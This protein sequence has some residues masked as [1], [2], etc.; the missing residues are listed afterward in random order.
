MATASYRE[1]TGRGADNYQRDF[2]P[3]IAT[4]VSEEL[5]RAA[6]LRPGERVLDVACGTGLIAR[7]AAEQVGPTGSVVGV[8]VAPD[9]IEVARSVPT[10]DGAH[11][12][13]RVGDACSLALEPEAFDAVLCQ[14]GIMFM[15]DQPK[16]TAEMRRVLVH[17]GRVVISAPGAIQPPFELMEEAIAR[18]ISPD[19]GL[20]VRA[21][22]SM[23]DPA[24]LAS[25]LEGA[26]F[27]DVSAGVYHATL[28]LPAPDEF[29]WQYINLTPMGPIVADAPDEARARLEREVVETWRPFVSGGRTPVDQPMVLATGR[30]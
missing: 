22:F 21:V 19:L 14:M 24:Q 12:D 4:P 26:G 3:A 29:L 10:R 25:L 20:F 11:V 15:E 30:A 27:S 6:R 2:V 23:A 28:Q 5:L 9:M 16:A 13:W 17:G 7:L 18:H 8:D 1:F